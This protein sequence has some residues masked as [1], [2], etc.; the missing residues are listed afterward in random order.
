LQARVKI[1]KRNKIIGFVFVIRENQALCN[2]E[3]CTLLARVAKAVATYVVGRRIR[4]TEE[5]KET[6]KEGN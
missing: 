1:Y 5:I 6:M 2:T 3:R 4:P